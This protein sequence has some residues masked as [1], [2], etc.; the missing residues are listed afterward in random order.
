MS[1]CPSLGSEVREWVAIE[2]MKWQ[3]GERNEWYDGK[4]G[5]FYLGAGGFA[6]DQDLNDLARMEK[7]LEELGLWKRYVKQLMDVPMSWQWNDED[8]VSQII[9]MSAYDRV[10]IAWRVFER[11]S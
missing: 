11:G 6:P 8:I 1:E 5:V 4:G 3:R 10:R 2:I 9:K 7:K